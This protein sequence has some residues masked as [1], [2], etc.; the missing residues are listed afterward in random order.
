MTKTN[1]EIVSGEKNCYIAGCVRNCAQY[2][3]KV[4]DNIKEMAE[5]FDNYKVVISYDESHDGSLQVLQQYQKT[6]PME[7][8]VNK[9]PLS[10]VRAKNICDARNAIIDYMKQEDDKS[11]EYFIMMDFDDVCAIYMNTSNLENILERHDDWDAVSFNRYPYYDIWALSID[12]Y[13]FSCW[14]WGETEFIQSKPIV[15]ATEKYVTDKLAAM[16]EDELLECHSA[17]NGFCIYK[18]DKFIDCKYDWDI[19]RTRKLITEE[20]MKKN[21]TVVGKDKIV[22]IGEYDEEKFNK[23]PPS[24]IIKK[25]EDCEHRNFHMEAIQKNGARIRI[26]PSFLFM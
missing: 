8:I 16:G 11:Y 14:H 1:I 10:K 9:R 2:L 23:E 18:K 21:M 19:N 13:L 24:G 22:Y 17:F 3:P 15:E 6:M 7:I 25:F 20:Q 4:F 26:S 12:P 5:L